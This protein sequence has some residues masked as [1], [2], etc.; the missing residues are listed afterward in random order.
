MKSQT[1][2][3]IPSSLEVDGAHDKFLACFPHSKCCECQGLDG[4]VDRGYFRLTNCSASS[5]LLNIA[6]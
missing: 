1:W 6:Y 2:S 5:C 3:P 4:N